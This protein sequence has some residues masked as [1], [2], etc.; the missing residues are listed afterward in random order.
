MDLRII[1]NKL[2]E[3]LKAKILSR[4]FGNLCKCNLIEISAIVEELKYFRKII[5]KRKIEKRESIM[6]DKAI[7]QLF[8]TISQNAEP[9]YKNL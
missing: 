1:Q 2:S 5:E 6:N 4:T 3:A 9:F 7:F 8:K